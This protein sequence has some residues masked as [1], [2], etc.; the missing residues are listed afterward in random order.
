MQDTQAVTRMSQKMLCRAGIGLAFLFFVMSSTLVGQDDR[1]T[2]QKPPPIVGRWDLT[3]HG[4]DGDYP[5]W[6]EVRQSGYRTL[7]GS[8]VGRTGSAG[9]SHGWGL[10]TGAST[11]RFRHNMSDAPTTSTLKAGSRANCS[12]A[13][14]RM[15]RADAS[16][17]K[18]AAR[19]R[20]QEPNFPAGA[21]RSSC[22][23][24]GTWL[25]GNRG[26]PAAPTDG[27]FEKAHW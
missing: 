26:I 22:L 1:F 17:G 3:V 2:M 10:R 24:G 5:S 27:S 7:V 18:L 8:F 19:P 4:S 21:I 20:S 25:A 16:T 12:A 15:T 14:R 11:S 23:T 9:P 6:L 13:K